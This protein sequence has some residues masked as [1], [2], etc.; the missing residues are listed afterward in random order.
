ML[1][2]PPAVV[3]VRKK[4][5]VKSYV[6]A[7]LQLVA[8]HLFT[9]H[10]C[11]AHLLALGAGCHRV[12]P[13][14]IRRT[15]KKG[16]EFTSANQKSCSGAS[17]DIGVTKFRACKSANAGRGMSTAIIRPSAAV[18]RTSTVSPPSASLM[19]VRTLTAMASGKS[20]SSI[21]GVPP[22]ASIARTLKRS[23]HD[24]VIEAISR[25][26]AIWEA[27]DGSRKNFLLR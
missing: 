9:H 8:C 26:S 23:P 12:Q 11:P 7:F 18:K 27:L 19:S 17:R 20:D 16:R 1:N 21:T 3:S 4:Q 10:H 14:R 5:N 25:P 24:S 2:R 6:S 15:P 13:E 22:G